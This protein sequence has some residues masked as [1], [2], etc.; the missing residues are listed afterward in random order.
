M[1]EF[2]LQFGIE[3]FGFI[4]YQDLVLFERKEFIRVTHQKEY[5][6]VLTMPT[7]PHDHWKYAFH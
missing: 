2:G 7:F 4:Y 1:A 5:E 6:L 3:C